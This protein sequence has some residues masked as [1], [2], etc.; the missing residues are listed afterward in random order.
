MIED[1]HCLALRKAPAEQSTQR[2]QGD[3]MLPADR[4]LNKRPAQGSCGPTARLQI[5]ETLTAEH[6][7]LLMLEHRWADRLCDSIAMLV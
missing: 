3:T 6:L 7:P 2:Q 4:V 5:S 1:C